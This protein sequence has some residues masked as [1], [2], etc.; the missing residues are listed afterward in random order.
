MAVQRV[1]ERLD[2]STRALAGANIPYAVVGG[3][4]VAAW[5]ATVDPGAVRNTADVDILLRSE[6]FDDAKAALTAAGFHYTRI[7]DVDTFLDGPDGRPRDAVHIIHA[8]TIVR[9][10]DTE[11]APSVEQSVSVGGT[12]FVELEPL[13]NMKLTAFRTKDR[14]H[15]LDMI[16]IELIDEAW[17]DKLP[18][19]LAERLQQL[20]DN[21]D[22]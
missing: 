1:K 15:L 14:M 22:G 19:E 13:V 6:D 20:L 9:K 16:E 3:H 5:V 8:G 10:G 7:L 4:A 21:P 2:R 11:S 18:P 17:L 12:R